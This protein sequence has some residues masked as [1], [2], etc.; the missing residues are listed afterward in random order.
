MPR[1]YASDLLV[2]DIDL[3]GER[4]A[5]RPYRSGRRRSDVFMVF[6]AAAASAAVLFNAFALQQGRNGSRAAA[7]ASVERTPRARE[8]LQQR[9]KVS[10]PCRRRAKA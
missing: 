3:D 4:V 1:S 7:P 6:V 8:L 5:G 2:D 10:M 9:E